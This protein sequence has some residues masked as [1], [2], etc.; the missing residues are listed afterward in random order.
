MKISKN[1]LLVT[2][3]AV[4]VATTVISCNKKDNTETLVGNWL[5]L[6]DF[7]GDARHEAVA[8]AIGEKGYVGTGYN[9]DERLNDFWVYDAVN[10][11]WTM[12]AT[13]TLLVPRTGA[14]AFSANGK[15]YVGTGRDNTKELKDFWEYTPETNTWLRVA[16]CPVARYGAV[17]FSINN[18][19]Y[20][21]TGYNGSPLLDFYAYNPGSNTWTPISNYPTKV[22]EAT[23]FVLDN[24]GYVVT[25]VKNGEAINDFFRFNPEDGT[26]SPMRK[27]SDVSSESYDDDYTIPRQKAVAFTVADR[28]Y[29][30]TG[31]KAGVVKD[32]WEYDPVKDL[33]NDKTS[34]EGSSRS[35]AVAFTTAS[36]RGFIATGFNGSSSY[37]DDLHEFRPNDKFNEDD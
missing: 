34:F 1:L 6:A 22:T 16:D 21:G 11:N 29:V 32:V 13:D 20:V 4:A 8:F 12:I 35:S 31:D 25:G 18:V 3:L 26:W 23:A 9:G 36:G 10:N 17:S 33:W 14:V 24:K 2:F 27:V 28:A 37:F 30:A 5:E 15:G 19:G 7:G